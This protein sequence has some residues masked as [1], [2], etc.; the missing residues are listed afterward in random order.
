M[1]ETTGIS[2]YSF[3]FIS[4][5]QVVYC[6]LYRPSVPCV[7]WIESFKSNTTKKFSR[8]NR[9]FLGTRH[10]FNSVSRRVRYTNRIFLQVCPFSRHLSSFSVLATRRR[11]KIDFWGFLTVYRAVSCATS[12]H[13]NPS[14]Q[15]TR[16]LL[17]SETESRSDQNSILFVE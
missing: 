7:E 15:S 16:I 9:Q 3:G 1:A 17:K 2:F 4:L 14:R 5:V 12:H 11:C 13:R 8:T 10:P 6:V